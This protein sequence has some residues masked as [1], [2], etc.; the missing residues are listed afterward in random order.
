MIKLRMIL[1]MLCISLVLLTASCQKTTTGKI[2]ATGTVELIVSNVFGGRY[3]I[4]NVSVLVVGVEIAL[5]KNIRL[6][7]FYFDTLV[8]DVFKKGQIIEI[9]SESSSLKQMLPVAPGIYEEVEIRNV[10]KFKIK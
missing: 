9:T 1:L 5:E 4:G 7:Y 6:H 10:V 3:S 8:N 2:I